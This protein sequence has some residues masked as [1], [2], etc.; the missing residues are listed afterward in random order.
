VL[1]AI[2]ATSR[3]T[4]GSRSQRERVFVDVRVAQRIV[5]AALVE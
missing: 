1:R 2:V 5:A 3:D 4:A